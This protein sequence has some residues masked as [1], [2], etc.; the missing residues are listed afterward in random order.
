MLKCPAAEAPWAGERRRVYL[1]PGELHASAEPCQITTILG[2]C[3]AVCLF[4][5]QLR[6]GGMNHYI[7]PAGREGEGSSTRFADIA[8]QALLERMMEL[9]CTRRNLAA[10]LFGGS[11][12]WNSQRPYAASLGAKNVETAREHLQRA[13]IPILAEDTGGIPGRKVI[14]HTDDGSVW[15]RRV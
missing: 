3:V 14:F 4:D 1:L 2:S 7:L 13:S 11:A 15:S 9:G 10:K 12:Q 8:M 5:L 6:I